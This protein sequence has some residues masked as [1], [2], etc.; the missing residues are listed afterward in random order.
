MGSFLHAEKVILEVAAS[1]KIKNASWDI[2]EVP[3]LHENLLWRCVG[4]FLPPKKSYFGG[5]S[6]RWIRELSDD[7]VSWGE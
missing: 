1:G 2:L 7:S 6:L 4:S 3:N 5:S